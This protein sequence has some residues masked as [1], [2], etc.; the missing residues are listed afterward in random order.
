M[1]FINCSYNSACSH[2][3]DSR[4]N[5]DP[6]KVDHFLSL[7]KIEW[8]RLYA[9]HS[10]CLPNPNQGGDSKTDK[11]VKTDRQLKVTT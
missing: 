6:A 5:T 11:Y 8:T 7:C 4:N 10:M 9:I 1:L 3:H 2:F